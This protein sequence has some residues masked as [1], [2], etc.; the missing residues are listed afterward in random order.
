MCTIN[1]S[2]LAPPCICAHNFGTTAGEIYRSSPFTGFC[3][4]AE[5]YFLHTSSAI[6]GLLSVYPSIAMSDSVS[7]DSNNLL[8]FEGCATGSGDINVGEQPPP[9]CSLS[10]Y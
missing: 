4:T 6:F 8:L 1:A 10:F 7:I 9:E 5:S 3:K 2:A